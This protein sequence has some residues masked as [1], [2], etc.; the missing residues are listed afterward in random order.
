MPPVSG[1]WRPGRPPNLNSELQRFRNTKA[2]PTWGGLLLVVTEG[3]G[4]Q[5]VHIQT[6]NNS[7]TEAT[8]KGGLSVLPTGH[9]YLSIMSTNSTSLGFILPR[10]GLGKLAQ[11]GSAKRDVL[12]PHPPQDP[13]SR[14]AGWNQTS[15]PH[16][17]RIVRNSVLLQKR[18]KL[19]LKINPPMMF[20]LSR[21]LSDRRVHLLLTNGKRAISFLPGKCF[22]PT[23]LMHPSR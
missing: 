8:R 19:R 12:G 11:A 4:L 16:E 13:P 7:S 22:N 15:S 14:R 2:A 5:P 9:A 6:F 18:H 21:D 3:Y 10:R 17:P 23:L 20:C 1:T